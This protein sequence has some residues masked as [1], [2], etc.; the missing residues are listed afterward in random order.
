MAV[1]AALLSSHPFVPFGF[2]GSP[3]GL[4]GT[5]GVLDKGCC[6]EDDETGT[7]AG[8]LLSGAEGGDVREA[9][10]DLLSFIDSASSNIKLALDK[11]GKSKRKVNHRKYL[12]KQIKR[13]SGLM[14]TAPPGP[15]S[16]SAADTPAK[17]P[18]GAPTV[19]AP[20]HGKAAPRREASQAAAAASLQSRSL[21]AL[22]DSL[23]HVPGAAE[24]AGGAVAS[25]AAAGLSGAGAAGTGEDA[26]GPVGGTVVPGSRKVP[27]RARNLPPSFFTEPSR[28]GGGSGGCGPSTPG[29][30]LGDLE[31][32]AEAAEFFELLGPDYGAAGT[33]AGVL[34]AAEPL[35]VFPSAGAVLR[36]T[37]ELEPGLFEPPPAMVGSL[38][39]P[40]TWST[41]GCSQTKKPTLAAP[42]GGLTLNEPLRPLY[43]ASTDSP[44]GEDGSGHLASFAPFFPD[45]AL[46]P[47]AH[48]VSYDYSSGY[49]RSTYSSLWRPDG[50]WEGA[51]GEEGARRD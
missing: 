9:T 34:L 14:G 7:P 31:K 19:A 5:F 38:L 49:S 43:A 26:A 44:G 29:V 3:D 30:S 21:A 42:R 13:C 47:P 40:E 36:A 33:E 50:G 51:P 18:P 11:P 41:P 28:A 22:F 24:P 35:D 17:R 23:R 10:R 39:Y 27:L 12:Q 16:P 1:Q 48:P 37:P 20:A 8:A 25:P 32:G 2:G 4:G 46:P 45:C 15:P 6:Y